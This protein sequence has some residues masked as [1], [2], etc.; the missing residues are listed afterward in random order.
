MAPA[1]IVVL[2]VALLGWDIADMGVEIWKWSRGD[3]TVDVEMPRGNVDAEWDPNLQLEIPEYPTTWPMDRTGQVLKKKQ[4]E[5]E[6]EFGK[7]H[8]HD[9]K[10]IEIPAFKPLEIPTTS[11]AQPKNPENPD[12][13]EVPDSKPSDQPDI[14]IPQPLKAPQQD[15]PFVPPANAT[16]QE[17]AFKKDASPVATTVGGTTPPGNGNRNN[18]NKKRKK[19][20]DWGSGGDVDYDDPLQ[21]WQKK[22]GTWEPRSR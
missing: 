13:P 20:K 6:K 7:T 17:I 11:P 18:K 8:K 22:Y 19:K 21:R 2:N 12:N 5:W 4:A 10:P 1:T 15:I 3:K 14:K 9:G 16:D